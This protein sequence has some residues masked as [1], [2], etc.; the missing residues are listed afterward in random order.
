MKKLSLLVLLL[1]LSAALF[2]QIPPPGDPN[3]GAPPGEVPISGIEWLLVAGGIFGVRK[4]FH[5]IRKG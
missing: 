5:R 4:I 2:G 3:D 1:F